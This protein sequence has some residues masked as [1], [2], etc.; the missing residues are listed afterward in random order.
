MERGIF[1][2]KKLSQQDI[3]RIFSDE[4]HLRF[5]ELAALLLSRTNDLKLIF[6]TYFSKET[7]LR[8]WRPIKAEMRKNKWADERI[9]YWDRVRGALQGSYKERIYKKPQK[10][11]KMPEDSFFAVLRTERIKKR[12]TQKELADK[13]GLSQQTISYAE[14]EKNDCSIGTVMK[15][16]KALGLQM[17]IIPG[18]KPFDF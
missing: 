3:M 15:I 9:D 18:E 17:K 4:N 2:D 6:S 14:N 8:N 5:V 16:L 10:A 1:W 12:M 13:T 7:F 11:K